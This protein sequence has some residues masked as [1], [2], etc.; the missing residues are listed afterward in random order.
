MSVS[1]SF[2]LHLG[3]RIKSTVRA[4]GASWVPKLW[5]E[6]WI[7]YHVDASIGGLFR[8]IDLRTERFNQHITNGSVIAEFGCNGNTLEE[9][10]YSAE[11]LAEIINEYIK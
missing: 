1:S 8:P 10:L 2:L 9:A 6:G 4:N 5:G 7:C 11:L 3:Y